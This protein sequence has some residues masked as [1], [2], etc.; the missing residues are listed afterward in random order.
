MRKLINVPRK[1]KMSSIGRGWIIGIAITLLV[2]G[3]TGFVLAATLGGAFKKPATGSTTTPAVNPPVK[4]PVKP[5]LPM[6]S[7]YHCHPANSRNSRN[8]TAHL[9]E[10]IF[11]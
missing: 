1:F 5:A 10:L 2:I 11:S 7:P 3:I 4:P 6:G 8:L 9:N